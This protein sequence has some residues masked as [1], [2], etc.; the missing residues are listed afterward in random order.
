MASKFLLATLAASVALIATFKWRFL[1]GEVDPKPILWFKEVF[2][3]M[4]YAIMS[5][6]VSRPRP[7]LFICCWLGLVVTDQWSS[8]QPLDNRYHLAESSVA[9]FVLL[10]FVECLLTI[11]RRFFRLLRDPNTN[12][13][14][15]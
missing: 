9:W 13:Q 4:G 14:Y 15:E 3:A 6:N 7:P 5:M 2:L 10:G 12:P 1:G 8:F 11:G